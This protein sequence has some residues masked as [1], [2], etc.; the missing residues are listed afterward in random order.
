MATQNLF[1]RSLRG[2]VQPTD[3]ATLALIAACQ[4]GEQPAFQVVYGQHSQPVYRLVYSLLLDRQDAEDVVQETF[5]Y[6]FRN[7][8]RYDPARGAFRTWLFTIA[9]SRA[10]NARRRKWLPSIDLATLLHLGQEPAA[11]DD[12][13]P[14]AHAVRRDAHE[15]LAQALGKIS[16]RLREA[17]VL[18]YGHDL[19]YREMAEVLDCPQKTAESRVRLGHEALRKAFTESDAALLREFA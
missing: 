10:R 6:A 1:G 9:I 13:A 8:G 11:S 15:R 17:L 4:R 19:T 12:L 16:P 14:E 18:R 2:S 3:P 5:V 7:M